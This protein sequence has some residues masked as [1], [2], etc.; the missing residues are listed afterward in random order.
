[1]SFRRHQDRAAIK[2]FKMKV[3]AGTPFEVQETAKR[4]R[5]LSRN[6]VVGKQQSA[7]ICNSSKL[8]FIIKSDPG[9]RAELAMSD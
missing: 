1:M 5:T 9:R 7:N 4:I 6:K 3:L 2:L 8:D